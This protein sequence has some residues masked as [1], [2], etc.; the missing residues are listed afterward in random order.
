MGRLL[1]VR[2]GES[3]ANALRRFTESELNPLSPVGREQAA[4]T[5]TLL[6]E[7][8]APVRIVSSPFARA[9]ETA[10]IIASA[11]GFA[12][13]IEVEPAVREQS[14]GALHGQPF[15]AAL[16]TP[17]FDSLVRWEWRP[18]GGETLLEVQTRAVPA[19]RAIAR[20]SLGRDVIVTSHSGTISA[21]WAHVEGSWLH[22]P[23]V[24]NCSVVL[25]EHD[26]SEFGEPELLLPSSPPTSS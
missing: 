11:L 7:R 13:P 24:P 8:F 5:A 3:Q 1:L 9:R 17:G 20:S 23:P 21:F 25:V 12:Q 16:R 14:L 4:R 22:V 15:E 26:G 18:P 19:L 10:A 2:H 6:R